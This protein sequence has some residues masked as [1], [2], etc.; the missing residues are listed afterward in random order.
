[1]ST[2]MSDSH[3]SPRLRGK[4]VQIQCFHYKRS[5]CHTHTFFFF[6]FM[7]SSFQRFAY[8]ASKTKFIP[9][10]A[11]NDISGD[12]LYGIHRM[13]ADRATVLRGTSHVTTKHH[14]GGYSKNA[15]WKGYSHSFKTTRSNSAGILLESREHRHIKA[16]NYLLIN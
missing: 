2:R 6:F 14:L 12:W 9:F 7:R 10:N 5:A 15:L 3:A 1:M 4:V 8:L 13:C 16:I 11:R